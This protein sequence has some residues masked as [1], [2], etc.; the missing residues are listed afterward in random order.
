MI[1]VDIFTDAQL[2]RLRH[3]TKNRALRKAIDEALYAADVRDRGRE[4]VAAL[5]N[6]RGGK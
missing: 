3:I 4:R 6:A 5:L 2:R 1:T